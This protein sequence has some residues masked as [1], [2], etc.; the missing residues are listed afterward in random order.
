MQEPVWSITDV[1]GAVKDMLESAMMPFWLHGE[2]GTYSA[3]RSGHVYLVL[4]DS[5][6]Q[7]RATWFQ[8]IHCSIVCCFRQKLEQEGLFSNE[9]KSEL[10]RYPRRV[11]VIT[12]P[13]GA[14]VRDF[15][16]L[17]LNN[18][19]AANIAVYP[20]TMQ[21]AGCVK[22]VCKALDFF[23][24]N[25]DVDVVV[26]TRGGG[27]MEDLWSFNDET[28]ARKVA[29]S[30]LP[31]V[32]AIGHE[33]DFT[34][35][36]FVADMRASTPSA[37]ANLLF[38]HYEALPE[39]LNQLTQG[40]KNRLESSMQSA[41]YRYGS[42]SRHYILQEPRHLLELRQQQLDELD[43]GLLNRVRQKLNIQQHRLE[44]LEKQLK[45]L[46]PNAVLKRGFA[47]VKDAQGN[48]V[49][50]ADSELLTK[51]VEILLA[52]GGIIGKVEK[53]IKNP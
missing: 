47:M 28:L 29:A 31:V 35:C 1:N 19:P 17:A 8:Y 26:I 49:T 43:R 25:S 42:A 3:H 48:I 9:R 32:S 37:A 16:R 22:D 52:K 23:N 36:D 10:P 39:S 20:A 12:A 6:C 13:E 2:I 45:A 30:R 4:K 34:I 7:L 44:G 15:M 41:R 38:S 21:G 40:I 24:K 33:I 46:S 50:Q 53:I 11:G 27:S 18:F 5:N 51:N 14:A